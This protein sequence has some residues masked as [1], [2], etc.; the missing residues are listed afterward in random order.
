MKYQIKVLWR[1]YVLVGIRYSTEYHYKILRIF[2]ARKINKEKR[3]GKYSK[4]KGSMTKFTGEP[5]HQDKVNELR[6]RILNEL[7][8]QGR[9]SIKDIGAVL[10]DAKREKARLDA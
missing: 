8:S 6:D 9:T 2:T 3:M 5:T 10:I 1:L 7:Q 4:L